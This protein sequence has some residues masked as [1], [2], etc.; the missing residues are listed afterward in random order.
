VASVASSNSRNDLPFT[1]SMKTAAVGVNKQNHLLSS[2]IGDGN[3]G[4]LKTSYNFKNQFFCLFL[5]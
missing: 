4:H 5:E 2:E 1:T 3:L